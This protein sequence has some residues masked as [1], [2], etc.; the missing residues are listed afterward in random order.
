MARG[1]THPGRA[2][3]LSIYNVR[4][5]PSS[6]QKRASIATHGTY[7]N[8]WGLFLVSWLFSLLA[9]FCYSPLLFSLRSVRVATQIRRHL[10]RLSSPLSTTRPM[11]ILR[12][13]KK[14]PAFACLVDS[15][16]IAPTPSRHG[17]VSAPPEKKR[18]SSK[19]GEP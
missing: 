15:S 4:N 3:F 6:A 13:H 11:L 9:S 12:F 5:L 16:L 10:G 7:T 18:V 19:Y 14:A 8:K 17:K 1:C 2:T